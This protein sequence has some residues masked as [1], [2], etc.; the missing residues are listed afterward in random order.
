MSDSASWAGVA[1]LG[2]HLIQGG[3]AV[4]RHFR[5][6][7]ECCGRKSGVSWD[8]GTPEDKSS[9]A[10]AGGVELKK[11]PI[12]SSTPLPPPGLLPGRPGGE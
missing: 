1:S 7:S 4:F 10:E 11:L 12:R 2:I 6:R 8:V 3:A 5:L 9:T